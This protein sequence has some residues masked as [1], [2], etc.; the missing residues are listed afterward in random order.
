MALIPGPE[1]RTFFSENTRCPATKIKILDVQRESR[2]MVGLSFTDGC[3]CDE[4]GEC[5]FEAVLRHHNTTYWD[6]SIA[7]R[8]YA[9]LMFDIYLL[10]SHSSGE[11][12]P[13]FPVKCPRH[14]LCGRSDSRPL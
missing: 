6:S 9:Q 7:G 3:T 11:R 14:V 12:A 4:C 8:S 10:W 5:E 13:V 2:E 1:E